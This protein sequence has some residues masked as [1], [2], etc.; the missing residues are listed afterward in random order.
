[1]AELIFNTGTMGCSKT[2][3]LLVRRYDAIGHGINVLTLKPSVDTR[4]GKNV[5]A[6]RTGLSAYVDEFDEGENI[7]KKFKER[8]KK[9]DI[10]FIDE[11][12]FI[13]PEQA[14][15]LY[16]IV[17]EF[18]IDV[19]AYGLRTN[20]KLGYFAG[21]EQLFKYC[22]E[23]RM[24]KNYCHCG[25]WAIVNARYD[26]ATGDILY[27]GPIIEIG[28]NERYLGLCKQCWEKGNV[29]GG[30]EELERNKELLERDRQ[31]VL[32]RRR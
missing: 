22:T 2:L 20:F 1:M 19:Q 8:L 10:V 11:V 25:N 21:S 28:G 23:I 6:S 17:K 31:L 16:Q 13:S 12:E 32:S 5:L 14:D 3:D 4:D 27:D 30:L 24:F 9:T 7:F 15:Q 29:N 26:G 18:H